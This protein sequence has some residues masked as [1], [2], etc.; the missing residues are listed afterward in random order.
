MDVIAARTY[1][2]LVLQQHLHILNPQI[3]VGLVGVILELI[4]VLEVEVRHEVPGRD[5]RDRHV[6]MV[7]GDVI[8]A[9]RCLRDAILHPISLC[10]FGHSDEACGVGFVRARPWRVDMQ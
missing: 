2:P 10:S 8:E 4:F 6:Q 9:P 1:P 3:H 7:L 5:A